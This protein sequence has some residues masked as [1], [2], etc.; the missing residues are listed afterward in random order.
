LVVKKT[1]K[2]E[3]PKKSYKLDQCA[4]Y[5]IKGAGQLVRVLGWTKGVEKLE[6][7]VDRSDNY[8]VF[9]DKKSQRW[10][11][12]PK[13]N[14]DKL[15]SRIATLLRR[16]TPPDYRQSGVRGRSFLTNAAE[17]QLENPSVKIDLE[18]FYPSTKFSHVYRFFNETM[19]CAS[20]V[21]NLLASIC[22]YQNAYLPT[23][24]RH[25]EV[26]AFYCHKNIFEKIR[27]RADARHGVMTTYIDDLVVT[28]AS[29]SSGDFRWIRKLFF[30]VGLN[31]NLKKSRIYGVRDPK[32]ITGVVVTKG[33]KRAPHKQHLKTLRHFK[34]LDELPENSAEYKTHARRLMGHLNH[35]ASIDGRFIKKLFGNRLRLFKDKS[36]V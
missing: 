32:T 8:N 9:F 10:I 15:Q 27:D 11:Q 24:A 18:K 29:A 30:A 21:A 33:K 19:G 2:L 28:M 16:V 26:L 13:P 23:G 7:L 3:R 36:K 35:I 6:A 22:C 1:K 5:K 20:D 14:I 34:A 31:L 12:H 17:H 4:L 25:S